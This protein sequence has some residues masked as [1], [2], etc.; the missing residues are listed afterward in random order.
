[1]LDIAA[2][3]WYI[4]DIVICILRPGRMVKKE[5]FHHERL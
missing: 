2:V 4:D 1:M 5:I 3:W